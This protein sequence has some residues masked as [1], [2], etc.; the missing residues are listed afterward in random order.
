MSWWDA[1]GFSTFA[2]QVVKTAQKKIDRVLDI[3]GLGDAQVEGMCT[4]V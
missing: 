3:D 2:T 1:A 4:S